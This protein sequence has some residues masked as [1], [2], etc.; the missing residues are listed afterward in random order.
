MYHAACFKPGEQAADVSVIVSVLVM[1]LCTV[2]VITLSG[3]ND[4]AGVGYTT[5]VGEV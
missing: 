2:G 4:S 5:G 3:H 1:T